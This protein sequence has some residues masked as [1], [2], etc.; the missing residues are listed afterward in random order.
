MKKAQYV[1]GFLSALVLLF[2]IFSYPKVAEI[3]RQRRIAVLAPNAGTMLVH[4]REIQA[5]MQS[6]GMVRSGVT[7]ENAT[8]LDRYKIAVDESAG[9]LEKLLDADNT[10]VLTD[11][12]VVL[13]ALPDVTWPFLWGRY[14]ALFLLPL[15]LLAVLI[16]MRPRRAR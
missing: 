6:L 14:G 2:V 4:V 11:C 10:A 3:E 16:H 13:G 9:R 7:E 15:A 8:V 5:G 12:R 1:L